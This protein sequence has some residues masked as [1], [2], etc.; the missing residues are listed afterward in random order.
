MPGSGQSADRGHW[1]SRAR[2]LITPLHLHHGL[3]AWSQDRPLGRHHT[4]TVP[5]SL[6][7]FIPRKRWKGYDCSF[8]NKCHFLRKIPTVLSR[9]G[10]LPLD[11]TRKSLEKRSPGSEQRRRPSPCP[12]VQTDSHQPTL[13]SS[14][15]TPK[16]SNDMLSPDPQCP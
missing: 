9:I 3:A 11:L 13:K 14:A 2:P 1:G 12:H 8:K 4:S 6:S 10:I 5:T 16:Y 15:E 7:I